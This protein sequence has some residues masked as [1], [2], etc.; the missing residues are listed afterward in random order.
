M[1]VISLRSIDLCNG[2]H[3]LNNIKTSANLIDSLRGPTR[4]RQAV[5]FQQRSRILHHSLEIPLRQYEQML[6]TKEQMK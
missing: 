2:G 6:G 5:S 4:E 3:Y 1:Q